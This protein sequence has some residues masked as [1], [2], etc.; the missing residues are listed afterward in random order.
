ATSIADM[1]PAGIQITPNPTEGT[2]LVTIGGTSTGAVDIEVIHPLG[3]RVLDMTGLAAGATFQLDL[4]A[5][6]AG[7]YTV[8]LHGA[9]QTFTQRVIVQHARRTVRY[10]TTTGIG[11]APSLV[12]RRRKQTPGAAC[13]RK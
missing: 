10:R 11:R 1:P 9:R 6:S 4:S 3:S 13:S 2:F 8:R 7:I 12:V 5:F